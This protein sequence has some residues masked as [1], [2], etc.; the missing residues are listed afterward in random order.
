MFL[1]GEDTQWY[2]TGSNFQS[3]RMSFS[4]TLMVLLFLAMH[5]YF[6]FIIFVRICSCSLKNF[7]KVSNRIF[8]VCYASTLGIGC[9]RPTLWRGVLGPA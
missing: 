7:S 9:R 2:I 8:V 6:S 1:K 4:K 3:A 5:G